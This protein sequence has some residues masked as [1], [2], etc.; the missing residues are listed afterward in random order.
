[1]AIEKHEFG[2]VYTTRD[3]F[4]WDRRT[5]IDIYITLVPPD[6]YKVKI[7]HWGMDDWYWHDN[8]HHYINLREVTAYFDRNTPT[9]VPLSY[10]PSTWVPPYGQGWL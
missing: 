9:D 2:L 10:F 5:P 8:N 1:M 4:A 6:I 3:D 7:Q